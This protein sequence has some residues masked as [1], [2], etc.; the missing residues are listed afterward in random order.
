MAR[1]ASEDEITSQEAGNERIVWPYEKCKELVQLRQETAILGSGVEGR[2]PRAE[3][4]T[5]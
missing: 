2:N 1:A 5:D 4:W 3:Q